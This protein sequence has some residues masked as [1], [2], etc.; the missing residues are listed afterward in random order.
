MSTGTCR[1]KKTCKVFL[2]VLLF[3]SFSFSAMLMTPYL[4]AVQ[5]DSIYVLVEC[6][7]R[8]QV[9]VYFGADL[10]YGNSQA[11]ESISE[12]LLARPTYVHKIKLKGLKPGALYHYRASQA[13]VYS[14]D[15]TFNTAVEEGTSFRFAWMADCRTGTD[16][17]DAIAANIKK[18]KPRFSL[19]GG[20]LCQ[21]GTYKFF[22]DEF[23]LKNELALIAEVPFFNTVGN[24]EGNVKN[25]YAFTE[26]P[27]SASGN[28]KYYSFDYGDLHVLALNTEL[29][30]TAENSQYKFVKA[31][32]E[33][34]KKKW[35]LVITHVPAYVDAN[36]EEDKKLIKMS[37]DLFE[38]NKVDMMISGHS[39]LYQHNL[40]NGIHYMIIGSAGAPLVTA[41]N[42]KPY[43]VKSVE[44]YNYAIFDLSA[45]RLLMTV[46]NEKEE[47][48]DTLELK[49][50]G[51]QK[52]KK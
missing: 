33:A 41:K 48:L 20:D 52:L 8:E 12:T 47:V 4:Q 37:R 15:H 32:L 10:K 24:H 21:N 1:V 51:V 17:H 43:V 49:K 5:K 26:A 30:V 16:V 40:V 34:C 28:Q 11:E 50:D 35:K 29:S 25:T 38:P 3:S 6:D 22:K 9:T 36:Y 44:D 27:Q 13:G 18:A 31:D 39:H 23:F 19:Y 7:T 45:E 46:Y 2:F 14:E 42:D